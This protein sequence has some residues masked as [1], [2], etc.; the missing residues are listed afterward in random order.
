MSKRISRTFDVK[1]NNRFASEGTMIDR[2]EP[3]DSVSYSQFGLDSEV[4]LGRH[5]LEKLEYPK[6]IRVTITK[7]Y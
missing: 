6:A 4:K 1:E 2:F 7:L 3:R 5:D